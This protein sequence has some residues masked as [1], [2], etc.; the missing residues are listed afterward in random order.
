MAG[1][2]GYTKLILHCNG[3][4]ES[5][6]FTDSSS[7]PHTVTPHGTAQIDTAQSQFGGASGLLDG[8]SDYLTMV[9]SD[10]WYFSTGDFTIDFWIRFNALPSASGWQMVF[11]QHKDANNKWRIYVYNSAGTYS[12]HF[13]HFPN[14]STKDIDLAQNTT[15]STGTWYHIAIIRYGNIWRI[16]QGGTQLGTDYNNTNDVHNFVASLTIGRSVETSLNYVN[17][18]LDEVRISVGIARWTS[19]FTPPTEEYSAP[20][21]NTKT[22]SSITRV[23]N[24][25]IKTVSAKAKIAGTATLTKTVS[26]KS[27]VKYSSVTNTV[28]AKAK[29]EYEVTKT[30]SAKAKILI[31]YNGKF[32]QD[33]YAYVVTDTTPAKIIKIDLTNPASYTIETITGLNNGKDWVINHNK[34]YLYTSLNHG[35]ISKILLSDPTTRTNEYLGID[36]QLNKITHNEDYLITYAGDN[37]ADDSLFILDE[38]EQEVINTDFRTRKE[39]GELIETFFGT[40]K[41]SKI[42]TDF[43]TRKETNSQINTDLRF[44]KSEYDEIIPLARTDFHVFIG[45]LELGDDDLILSSIRINSVADNKAN[46]SFELT[47]KHD[48]INNPTTITNNN[49]VTIYIGTSPN[50]VLIFTGRINNLDCRSSEEKVGVF[51]ESEDIPDSINYDFSTKDLPLTILNSQIHLY[52]VLLNDI[53]I[54][55]PYLNTNLIIVSGDGLYWTGTA[56]SK[57]LSEALTFATAILATAYITANTGNDI[58]TSKTPTVDNYERNPKYYNGIK[59]NLGTK[60]DEQIIQVF[61]SASGLATAEKIDDGTFIFKPNYTYFWWVTGTKLNLNGG[62]SRFSGWYI[63]TSLAPLS[64]DLYDI[65]SISYV[66]QKELD[67]VETELGEYCIGTAPYKEVSSKNGVYISKEKW[68][69][70]DDGRY[71]EKTEGYDYQDYIVQVSA[72]EFAKIKNING[73]ILPKTTASIEL[74]LD[75]YLYYGLKLLTRLNLINTT[76]VQGNI[77]KSLNGFPVAIKQIS[78]DSSSMKVSLSCDN[79]QSEYELG[80]LDSSYPAESNYINPAISTKL[81]TK[82]DLPSEKEVES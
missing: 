33:T 62:S 43:R 71:L 32:I 30:V 25:N 73:D 16:F 8:N 5:T 7:A 29:I 6:T 27:R 15:L 39:T 51:A 77:Y 68:A 49:I 12:W 37:I 2:D 17:G 56:W 20:V 28:S 24:T 55:K 67:N 74:T 19:D 65:D 40:L 35:Y 59:I 61:V 21:T 78:I 58:L 52:D 4:D 57:K 10:D 48:D 76:D 64:G 1:I 53:T 41:G 46:A 14:S 13:D 45:G 75:G 22:V 72:I 34:G 79:E 81:D 60:T 54:D 70:K 31:P 50:G 42:N 66:Y 9:D 69:D 36:R 47:R 44:L 26:V 80:L 11:N 23:F 82:Y 63:G 18:W 3:D 38:S